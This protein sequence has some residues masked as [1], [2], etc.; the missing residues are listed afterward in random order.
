MELIRPLLRRLPLNNYVRRQLHLRLA[1]W[2]EALRRL[3]R[4]GPLLLTGVLLL[5]TAGCATPRPLAPSADDPAPVI[6]R[7][8]RNAGGVE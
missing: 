8:A 4:R 7:L 6:L 5:A 1:R 3:A 2:A